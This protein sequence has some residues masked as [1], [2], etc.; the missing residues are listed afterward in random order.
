MW[1]VRGEVGM[2]RQDE[3]N[4]EGEVFACFTFHPGWCCHLLGYHLINSRLLFCGERLIQHPE[5]EQGKFAWQPGASGQGRL[6]LYHAF[7]GMLNHLS[8]AFPQQPEQIS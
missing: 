8:G 1:G 3:T 2:S 7:T 4:N 5:K 6:P